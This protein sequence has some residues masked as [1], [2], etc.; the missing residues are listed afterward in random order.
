MATPNLFKFATSELS[1]DAFICWLLSWAKKNYKTGNDKHKALN[2]VAISVLALL[3]DKAGK[4]LPTSIDSI[5]VQRQV[6]NID[7]RVVIKKL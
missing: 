7:I 4:T 6:S 3:F 1:Q 5:V 2:K